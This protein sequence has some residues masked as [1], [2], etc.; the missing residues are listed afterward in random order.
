MK[1]GDDPKVSHDEIAYQTARR[2]LG[3]HDREGL[4]H[5]GHAGH[6]AHAGHAVLK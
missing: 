3:H 4:K 2:F 5:A 1:K 6:A